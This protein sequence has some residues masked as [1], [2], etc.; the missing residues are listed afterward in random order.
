MSDSINYG[1]AGNVRA[2]AVAVGT[3]ARASVSETTSSEGRE[4]LD[5]AINELIIQLAALRLTPAAHELVLGDVD[6]LR[7]V[8]PGD[9]EARPHVSG[10]LERLTEKLKMVNVA[11]EAISPL[12][13]P[14]KAIAALFGV[15]LPF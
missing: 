7:Q 12:G 10:I 15:P 14:L 13:G 4:K 2:K 1:I 5:G 11:I 6:S 8:D 9:K 3:G